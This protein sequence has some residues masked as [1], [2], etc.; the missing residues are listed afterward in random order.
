MKTSLHYRGK[1]AYMSR[2]DVNAPAEERAQV[3]SEYHAA[4]LAEDI[5]KT[6]AKSPPFTQE[7]LQELYAALCGNSPGAAA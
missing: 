5:A 4:R 7:Q 1:L 3:R 6:V 2:R